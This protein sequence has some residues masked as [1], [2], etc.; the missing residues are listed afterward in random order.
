MHST[1]SVLAPA[2][3]QLQRLASGAESV[4]MAIR[5][6]RADSPFGACFLA[7]AEQGVCSL[8]FG[9]EETDGAFVQE[10]RRDFPKARIDHDGYAA[11]REAKRIFGAGRGAADPVRVLVRGTDLQFRVWRA[12]CA[13]PAGTTVS[14]QALAV[15]VDA[16]R[17][18]RAVA[19]AVG[20]NRVAWLIPCHRVIRSDGSLGGY[21]WG[22]ECKRAILRAE[23]AG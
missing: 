11:V 23:A 18:V 19:N 13:I 6:G 3:V 14:Y 8:H 16:P 20:A 7:W 9:V 22:L 12:L 1:K 17:A 4:G 5:W 10:L 15:R 2:S 21:R